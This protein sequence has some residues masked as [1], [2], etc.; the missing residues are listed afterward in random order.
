MKEREKVR[1]R[2]KRWEDGDTDRKYFMV[3]KYYFVKPAL[4][5]C[6]SVPDLSSRLYI[7]FN[8]NSLLLFLMV[9]IDLLV[10]SK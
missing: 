2:M 8:L 4:K 5:F 7:F 9:N 10:K 6:D 3:L 1:G